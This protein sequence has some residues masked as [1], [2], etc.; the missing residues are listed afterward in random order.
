LCH[1]NVVRIYDEMETDSVYCLVL[2]HADGGD[3]Y[4]WTTH[5]HREDA[6]AAP[7]PELVVRDIFGQLACAIGYLHQ[8]GI[9]H[10]DV[11][12]ENILLSRVPVSTARPSG[13]RV[14]LA[15]FG[16]A[17]AQTPP[18]MQQ[19]LAAGSDEYAAPEVV[20]SAASATTDVWALGIVLYAL[21][22][23]RL[24]FLRKIN[25]TRRSF[26]YRVA[27]G[28]VSFPADA[29]V[30]V[31]AA[32]LARALL[33]RRP[34]ERIAVAD[35]WTMP[36]LHGWSPVTADLTTP[37]PST[38]CAPSHSSAM[39]MTSTGDADAMASRRSHRHASAATTG[40]AH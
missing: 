14:I 2:E 33:R 22:F 28:D 38:A 23:G 34:G 6:D 35:I 20:L 9:T 12:L 37:M 31:P 40:M 21:L 16:L 17:V 27:R 30:S 19:P 18:D 15:D 13:L 25:Q 11:K 32:D 3:L 24:P 10:R 26:L 5:L 7:L 4:D 8:Q 36:W 29:T 1:P 39:G